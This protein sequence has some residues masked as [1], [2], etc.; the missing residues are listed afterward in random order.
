MWIWSGPVREIV[1]PIKLLQSND[2]I[3]TAVPP[4]KPKAEEVHLF[5]P[6]RDKC[7]LV[8]EIAKIIVIT[9]Y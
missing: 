3:Y 1:D 7:W 6:E 9:Y 4:S 2:V 8:V 5:R